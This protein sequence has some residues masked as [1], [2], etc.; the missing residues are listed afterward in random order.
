MKNEFEARDELIERRKDIKSLDELR[1]FIDDIEKNYNYDYGV[2]PRAIAQATLATADFLSSRMGIT[3]FQASFVMWD[4]IKGYLYQ[5]NECGLKI[6]NYDEMLFP[7]YKHKF[8]K[9]ISKKTWESIQKKAREKLD[10]I[11]DAHPDI[12][13]HWQSIVDGNVPYGYRV[14]E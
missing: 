9:V 8:E 7:Q 12:I 2:A 6:V 1:E 11:E 10:N 5:A 4:F 14:E 3:G 13:Q